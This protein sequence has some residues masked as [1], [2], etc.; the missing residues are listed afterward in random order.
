MKRKRS[1]ATIILLTVLCV[2]IG[3]AVAIAR[4]NRHAE[5]SLVGDQYMTV[6][7]GTEFVD[8]GVEAKSVG[9]SFGTFKKAPKVTVTG[10]VDTGS[11][12]EYVLEYTTTVNKTIASVSRTVSVV[13]TTPPVIELVHKEGYET[14]WFT[15]YEEEGYT[16]TDSRDGDL[17]DKVVRKELGDSILYTVSDS[18]GNEAQVERQ[19]EYTVA[20]P[21]ILLAGEENMTLG[22]SLN[23]ADPGYSAQDSQGNDLTESVSVSGEVCPYKL[24]TYKIEYSISNQQGD[25]VSRTRT[26]EVVKAEKPEVIKP[27]EKTIYLTFDDGPGPYTGQLLDILA[28]YDVKATFFV[29]GADS[30]YFDMIGR[31]YNEGHTI[32]VHTYT[33]NYRKIY[34]SERNFFE[35]FCKVEELIY[36]QTGSYTKICRFPGGSSNTVS[37]FNPGIMSRLVTIMNDMGYCYFDWNVSSG[38][39][40]ET[41]STRDIIYNIKS[42]CSQNVLNVVLQHDIKDYS[43]NA[44]ED[45]IIWGLNNGYTFR[46]LDETSWGSHHSLFN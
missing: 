30:D 18:C 10:E 37:S 25:K 26:V 32:G 4:D 41:N 22:A 43:V 35:D 39:A 3:L 28:E 7:Y 20:R 34:Q 5:I 2:L 44:V 40:G 33:H 6:E 14:D 24:G 21:E 42:G 11:L 1:G 16:A 29:T 19:I 46:A 15:G 8:P 17:T 38:D 23:F 9:R 13:D 27:E 45:V 31:A 12:G 36:E